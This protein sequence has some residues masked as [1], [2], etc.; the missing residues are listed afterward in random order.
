MLSSRRL[1]LAHFW[2]AF[3]GY[4]AALLLGEWQMFIRSLLHAWIS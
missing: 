2:F 4:G 1:I 3:A